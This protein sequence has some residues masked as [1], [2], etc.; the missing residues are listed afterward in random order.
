MIDEAGNSEICG[1]CSSQQELVPAAIKNRPGLDA[2][3]YRVGTQ[4]SFKA[5]M[6]KAL[7]DQPA[8]QA[9]TTR[10]DDD[11]TLA[12]L[13]AWASVLD[14]LTFYQERI[15]NEGYLRTATERRSVRELARAIGYE[16]KPGVAADAYLAFTLENTEGSPE[17]VSI[18]AGTKIQSV[19]EPGEQPQVFETIEDIEARPEW[20]ALKPRMTKLP[21]TGK[22]AAWKGVEVTQTELYLNGEKLSLKAGD[23]ILIVGDQRNSRDIRI[24]TEVEPNP[25]F[26]CTKI[27]WENGL[28][29]SQG[30]T[31]RAFFFRQRAALFGHN[32]PNWNALS[33]N[34]Q[35]GLYKAFNNTLPHDWPPKDWPKELFA[36]GTENTRQ[37]DLDAAYPNILKDSWIALMQWTSGNGQ[38]D[39]EL[40]KVE[41]THIGSRSDF[42]IT[43]KT[44][45]LLLD[46]DVDPKRFG[47]RDT[48]VLIQ[49]EPL[50][51]LRYI[52]E[53]ID[54]PKEL[55][56]SN[57]DNIPLS[58]MMIDEL[59]KGRTLIVSGVN[60]DGKTVG[61][62]VT[63]IG[64]KTEY[65]VTTLVFAPALEHSYQRDS[66]TISAN[67]ARA[68]QGETRQ[69][70]LGSGDASSANQKFALKQVPLTYIQAPTPS[71]GE[72]TLR[73]RVN[74]IMWKESPSLHGLK[75]H[76]RSYA[77]R[78]A[79]DGTAGIEFGDG[80][81]GA[82]LPSG[83][84]NVVA[85]YRVG[86]GA[87]GRVK[88]GQLQL[89]MTRPFGVKGVVNPLAAT[90]GADP[91]NLDGARQNAP[92][93]VL[94]LDRIVSLADFENFARGFS[95]I[96]K[97][98]SVWL[99]N[100]HARIVH[101]TVA[102]PGGL[103]LE[104]TDLDKLR[105]AMNAFRDP[106]QD[107]RIDSIDNTQAGAFNVVA[108]VL[109]KPDYLLEKVLR[110]VEDTLRASFSFDKRQLGQSVTQAKVMAVIQACEGVKAA[111]LQYL[112]LASDPK[113]KAMNST[114]DA[115]QAD[116]D[117]S[118]DPPIIRPAQI[119]FINPEADGVECQGWVG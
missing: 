19:P 32:A 82:R 23:A 46:T 42:A 83:I 53:P 35:E 111:R 5:A 112:Y 96:G 26:G 6:R 51:I 24:L 9:L 37:I 57:T 93:T 2:L 118:V 91:E 34:T 61:E 54:D 89:L 64:Q 117:K 33:A 73:I 20:N 68:T 95:G 44:T 1:C 75:V 43:G 101:I 80:N 41:A 67:V 66:L 59:P 36:I 92:S 28:A 79:E 84:E 38:P 69:E 114:L 90:G 10:Q 45:H 40:Y 94:A 77:V 16:L 11:P 86:T 87:A 50:E 12:L 74:D 48:T 30:T 100:G 39:I 15:A 58:T 103:K 27:K 116:L 71:G 60:Q 49:S 14:V 25:E 85:T 81:S 72:S 102:G 113:G 106:A 97:A 56:I 8:L 98:Q 21:Q 99:W 17:K 55:V 88:A 47:L 78:M 65:G 70:V 7:S 109:V 107:I 108:Q 115:Q 63:L 105:R 29:Y 13:D 31:V 110:T 52:D 3:A 18:N 76:D 104:S 22:G 4:G 62:L 119:L